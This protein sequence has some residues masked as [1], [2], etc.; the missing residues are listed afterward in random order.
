MARDDEDDFTRATRAY[1]YVSPN[2]S[3]FEQ[4]FLNPFWD[5]FV[6]VYPRWLAPNVI[7]VAGGLCALLMYALDAAQSPAN[8]GAA[9][10]H[11]YLAFAGLLLCYQ[12]LDGTDGKQARRTKSGSALGELM[13]HGVD[14]LVTGF[15]AMVVADCTQFSLDSVVPWACAF[16][17]QMTFY[18][19][20]LTLL[21][22][23][24]QQFNVVDIME[25]QWV[26]IVTLLVA[27][28]AGTDFWRDTLLLVPP[29]LEPVA[30]LAAHRA[31]GL[32]PHAPYGYMQARL[33]V[34]FGAVFGTVSNFL[35]YAFI[36]SEPYRVAPEAVPEHVRRRAPGTGLAALA[37]QIV[38]ILGYGALCFLARHRL[39]QAAE[40]AEPGNAA[41]R[42]D[43]LRALLTG[44][45]FAFADLMDRILVMRVTHHRV[46]AVPPTLLVVALFVLGAPLLRAR[47]F[48]GVRW[49]WFAALAGVASHLAF[50]VW[51]SRKL[52][53]ALG[54][55]VFRINPPPADVAPA[56]TV[57]EVG[58]AKKAA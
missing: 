50:F 34:A 27:G 35:M 44:S 46:P 7:S 28:V 25:L 32:T 43:A 39:V 9:P 3:L 48:L 11:M 45:C 15:V 49:W 8:E 20:N 13:D 5:R 12:T 54:I 47:A 24:R 42:H 19:S 4:L 41:L 10:Q 36:A 52:A 16:G 18:M 14:A 37:R 31:F 55:R 21:H 2:L 57:V 40:A 51:V 29:P 33:I 38:T 22:R 1:R 58:V 56:A 26:M 30:D 53:R 6:H 17:G 23:G